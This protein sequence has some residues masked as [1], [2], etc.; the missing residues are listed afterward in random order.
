[1][2]HFMKK[3]N[4]TAVHSSNHWIFMIS[5]SVRFI[6]KFKIL[7]VMIIILEVYQIF[8]LV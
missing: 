5:N 7:Q 6:I 8:Q 2:P 4:I 1:M 3:Y